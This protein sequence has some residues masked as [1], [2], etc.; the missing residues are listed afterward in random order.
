V[1]PSSRISPSW[2]LNDWPPDVYPGTSSKARYIVRVHRDELVKCG[3]LARVGRDLV[4]LGDRYAKWLQRRSSQVP[5][6]E[7]APN[8]T[9][10]PAEA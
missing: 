3:A 1:S 5:E 7:C 6:F 2:S 4:L 9:K 10:A 8:R